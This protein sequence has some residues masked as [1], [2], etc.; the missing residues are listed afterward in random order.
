MNVLDFIDALQAPDGASHEFGLT[1]EEKEAY[2]VRFNIGLKNTVISTY[3]VLS[4][5]LNK[6]EGYLEVDIG[7]DP[8]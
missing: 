6:E 5:Y 7:E 4:T 3:S 8:S 1:V 2:V